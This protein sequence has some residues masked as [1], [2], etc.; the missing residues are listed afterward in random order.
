LIVD[1]ST[2]SLRQSEYFP[3]ETTPLW[4]EVV[5]DY[6][7]IGVVDGVRLYRRAK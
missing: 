6:Q 5:R 2:T 1:T 3:L 4:G 7:L